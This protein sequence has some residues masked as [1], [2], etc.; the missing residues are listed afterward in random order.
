MTAQNSKQTANNRTRCFSTQWVTHVTPLAAQIHGHKCDIHRR[1][2]I[3]IACQQATRM[4]PPP[5][6]AQ[7]GDEAIYYTLKTHIDQCNLMSVA[8][9]PLRYLAFPLFFLLVQADLCATRRTDP[10]KSRRMFI[11]NETITKKPISRCLSACDNPVSFTPM[12]V[13]SCNSIIG[14]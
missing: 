4:T 10:L 14:S 3:A 2:M 13:F 7:P 8:M 6:I 5:T 1:A 9:K 11:A 12:I